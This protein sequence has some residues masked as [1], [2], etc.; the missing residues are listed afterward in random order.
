VRIKNVIRTFF[1]AIIFAFGCGES[2][3]KEEIVIGIVKQHDTRINVV[4]EIG[5]GKYVER[6]IHR[7]QAAVCGNSIVVADD[8][9]SGKKPFGP[10]LGCEEKFE[11]YQRKRS[12]K[13]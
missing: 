3:I 11:D 7:S 1:L 12:K 4:C 10:L 2:I 6:S 9:L 5:K 13:Y 8:Y